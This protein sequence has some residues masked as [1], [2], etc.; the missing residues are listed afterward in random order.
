MKSRLRF[1]MQIE[2]GS[3]QDR[4]W[5]E[6]G[7]DPSS[8][9][10][11]ALLCNQHHDVTFRNGDIDPGAGEIPSHPQCTYPVTHLSRPFYVAGISNL[12]K[13][14]RRLTS[15]ERLMTR[16]KM[17]TNEADLVRDLNLDLLSLFLLLKPWPCSI[18][19][20]MIPETLMGNRLRL[21]SFDVEN[22]WHKNFQR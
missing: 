6:L 11:G 16:V 2:L 15:L 1:A 22:H 21:A 3:T 5:I 7:I 18:F 12:W 17:M 4:I 10:L 13:L 9:R 8:F 19:K 20:N 14:K